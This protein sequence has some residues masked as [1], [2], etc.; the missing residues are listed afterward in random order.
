[1]V[2]SVSYCCVHGS[3]LFSS[4]VT[5]TDET[6]KQQDVKQKVAT[7]YFKI[8]SLINNLDK[9]L[10]FIFSKGYPIDKLFVL[11]KFLIR[12]LSLLWYFVQKKMWILYYNVASYLSLV[13]LI[14]MVTFRE[15]AE[16]IVTSSDITI[17]MGTKTEAHFSSIFNSYTLKQLIKGIRIANNSSHGFICKCSDS[18]H[19]TPSCFDR[20]TAGSKFLHDWLVLFA[21]DL[22]M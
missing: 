14:L 18:L 2:K 17:L 16:Y 3:Q 6:D 8:C 11:W 12:I 10:L 22:A 5:N 4:L 19:I 1:M 13:G 15:G 20:Q 7:V 21:V 9:S